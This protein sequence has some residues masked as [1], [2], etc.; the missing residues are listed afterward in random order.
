MKKFEEKR[1]EY[2]YEYK[3]NYSK[4]NIFKCGIVVALHNTGVVFGSK[5]GF[6]VGDALFVDTIYG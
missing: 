4:F 6:L 3:K 5:T 2:Y 1:K